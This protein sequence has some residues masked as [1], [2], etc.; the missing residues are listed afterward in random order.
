MN[1]FLYSTML[2]NIR[3]T[4]GG[5]VKKGMANGKKFAL[6][7]KTGKFKQLISLRTTK[8]ESEVEQDVKS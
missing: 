8:Q 3:K 5:K 7:A 1:I 4:M 6:I 2:F